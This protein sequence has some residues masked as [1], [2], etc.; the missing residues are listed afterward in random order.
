M[1]T[2][3][4]T[5]L[6]VAARCFG[7]SIGVQCPPDYEGLVVGQFPAG[8]SPIDGSNLDCTIVLHPVEQNLF[9]I[10]RKSSYVTPPQGLDFAISSLQNEIHIAIA[11]YAKSHVF[12]HAGVVAWNDRVILIPGQSYAGKS[13]L[14]WSIVQAGGVYFSDEFAVFDET[15][16]VEPFALPISLRSHT[17]GKSYEM[18]SRVASSPALPDL[19]LFARYREG[20]QWKPERLRPAQTAMKLL[21]HSVGAR[22]NPTLVLSV[23]KTIGL[24]AEGF[25]GYRDDVPP[26][27]DWLGE[28]T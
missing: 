26:V 5:S 2:R 21:R 23:L 11:E 24:R 7:V 28:R 18:P 9:R 10:R 8:W 17:G 15:G 16:R 27:L 14:V 3:N 4:P 19:V 1:P 22:R 13:T 25:E 20:K 12:I 6:L